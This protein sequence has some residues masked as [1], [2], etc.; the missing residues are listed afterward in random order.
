MPLHPVN[1]IRDA[2]RRGRCVSSSP[3]RCAAIGGSGEGM[4]R[5]GGGGGAA[6]GGRR[7]G[8]GARKSVPCLVI[9]YRGG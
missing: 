6:R 8:T 7:S 1:R 9:D 5:S 3:T 2:G 4:N